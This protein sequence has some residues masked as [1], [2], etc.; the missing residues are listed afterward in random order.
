[1]SCEGGSLCAVCKMY[2]LPLYIRRH[3]VAGRRVGADKS[4]GEQ[5][6]CPSI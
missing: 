3:N 2:E 6:L 1:M 5:G 4:G